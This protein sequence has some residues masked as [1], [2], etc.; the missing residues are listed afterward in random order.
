MVLGYESTGEDVSKVARANHGE[1]VERHR[2][3]PHGVRLTES[4]S[5]G[6]DEVFEQ[7]HRSR[8]L[9]TAEGH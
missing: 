6:P 1:F 7:Q 4:R 2:D 3:L 5:R 8:V 9:L